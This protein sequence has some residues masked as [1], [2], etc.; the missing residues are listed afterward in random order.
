VETIQFKR[1]HLWTK[2][3]NNKFESRKREGKL[4]E[5]K[6]IKSKVD[7]KKLSYYVKNTNKFIVI[8]NWQ[9]SKIKIANEKLEKY[10][11]KQNAYP[12][13]PSIIELK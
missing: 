6:C 1:I 10:V 11:P 5:T 7:L 9:S 8:K 13:K 4:I 2:Y 12:E 3:N